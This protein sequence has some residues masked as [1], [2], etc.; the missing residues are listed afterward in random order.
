MNKLNIKAGV[1]KPKQ[2]MDEKQ[3][4]RKVVAPEIARYIVRSGGRNM[5]GGLSEREEL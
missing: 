1:N 5:F 4:I 2:A 3:H